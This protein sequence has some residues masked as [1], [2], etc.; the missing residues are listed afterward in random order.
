MGLY[1][2]VTINNFI[3]DVN[4]PD[5]YKCYGLKVL[6]ND[7]VINLFSK[8]KSN[9]TKV[10]ALGRKE[11]IREIKNWKLDKTR[12]KNLIEKINKTKKPICLSVGC[13]DIL[14]KMYID[15][16]EIIKIIYS[17]DNWIDEDIV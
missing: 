12:L 4:I 6:D 10:K 13:E 9:E 16:V 7:D 3:I 11:V 17:D 15:E 14:L 5:D 2:K 1:D 8:N